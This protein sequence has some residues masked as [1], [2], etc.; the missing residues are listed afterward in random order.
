MS[1]GAS[2][3]AVFE[4][5]F[6]EPWERN[7]RLP[8]LGGLGRLRR[9]CYAMFLVH[10]IVSVGIEVG[11]E[12]AM[13]GRGRGCGMARDVGGVG[14]TVMAGMVNVVGSWA[15]AVALCRTRVGRWV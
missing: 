11:L 2:L 4:K 8:V 3:V 10:G 15:L 5:Y 13:M 9:Y 7:S 12:R 1:I 6:N 14:M